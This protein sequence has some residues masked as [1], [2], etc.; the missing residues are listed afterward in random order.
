MVQD[1]GF[2]FHVDL[3][4]N[5]HN[6][7]GKETKNAAKVQDWGVYAQHYL[8]GIEVESSNGED[9]EAANWGLRLRDEAQH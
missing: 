2:R 5:I 1:L 7:D 3:C 9:M 6:D 8:L 4:T